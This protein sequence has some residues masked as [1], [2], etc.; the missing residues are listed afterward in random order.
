MKYKF[1]AQKA[2]GSAYEGE[3]EAP[4]KF[5]LYQGFRNAGESVLFAG[6]VRERVLFDWRRLGT[7]LSRVSYHDKIVFAKN[8]SAMLEAGLSLSRA[9]EVLIRQTKK[10]QLKKVI[11][12]LAES[13]KQ[14]KQLSEA[15]SLHPTVFPPIFISMVKAGEESGSLAKSL[16]ALATQMDKM[17]QLSRKVRGALFYPAII[18]TVM[19][20]VGILMLIF[21][22]PSLT[23]TFK[24]LKIDL[25]LSTRI[26]I[27]VSDLLSQHTVTFLIGLV[28][29]A[30][31]TFAASRTLPGKKAIDFIFLHVPLLSRLV[32]ETNT[33]RTAMTFSSL[34][35]AGVSIINA[36]RITGEV[37]QNVYYRAVLERA[38]V[39]IEK[40]NPIAKVFSESEPLYPAFLSEM[41]S[42]GEETGK[43]PEMLHDVGLFYESEVEQQTRDLSTIIE[44]ILMV[45][46]GV[47]VGFFAVAMITPTYS[48]VN[49]I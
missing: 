6:L 40:G 48:L 13:V 8:L 49:S 23:A 3:R 27:L 19:V 7:V 36:L 17:Y 33:A 12:A 31:A 44:P 14:G 15:L 32:R 30:G 45:I 34:L 41:I 4:D 37:V 29:F 16:S 47:I 9:F 38:I 25:P 28:A 46:I 22:V 11:G 2:D 43:L 42:V 24:E 26:V 35:S 10:K 21:V 1:K 20:I 39:A 5:T 18:V